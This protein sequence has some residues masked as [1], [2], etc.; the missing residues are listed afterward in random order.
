MF[1]KKKKYFVT[2]IYYLQSSRVLFIKRE[3][4]LF[5]DVFWKIQSHYLKSIIDRKR[6]ERKLKCIKPLLK[7]QK[8]RKQNRK[9]EQ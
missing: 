1:W 5:V 3:L 7:P 4:G 2:T 6:Q 9:K 8:S